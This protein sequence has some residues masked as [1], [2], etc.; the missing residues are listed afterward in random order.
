[1]GGGFKDEFVERF[2]VNHGDFVIIGGVGKYVC[3]EM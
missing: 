1:M 3:F 2:G